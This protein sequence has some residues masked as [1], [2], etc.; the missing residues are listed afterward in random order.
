MNENNTVLVEKLRLPTPKDRVKFRVGYKS[1]D[2]SQA[3]MLAY[4]DA[5]YVQDTLDDIIGADNWNLEYH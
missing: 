2:E 1:R 4:V 5:R 3:C